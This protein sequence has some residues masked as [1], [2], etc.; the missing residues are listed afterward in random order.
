MFY[1]RNDELDN[2]SHIGMGQ[3]GASIMIYA[4]QFEYDNAGP[5]F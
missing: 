4:N 5:E 1:I 2:D 3:L